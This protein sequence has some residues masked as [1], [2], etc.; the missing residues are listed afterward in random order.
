MKDDRFYLIHISECL[1]DVADYTAE[2]RASFL[3]SKMIQDAVLRKLQIMVQS[4]L[5]LS[6]AFREAHPQVEWDKMRGFRNFVVHEYLDIDLDA[7]W[8]IVENDL[9][10]LAQAIEVAV[11][12]LD[13]DN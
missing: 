8:Y 12:D 7:V 10:P 9:P 6:D 11:G 4:S 5:R 3:E 13:Q 1:K 2:G